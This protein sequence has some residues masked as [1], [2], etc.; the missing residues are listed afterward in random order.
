M[1]TF[2]GGETWSEND[3]RDNAPAIAT[4]VASTIGK[5]HHVTGILAS[6]STARVGEVVITSGAQTLGRVFVHNSGEFSFPQPLI[7]LSSTAVTATLA[8]SGAPGT[9]GAITLIGYTR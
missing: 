3:N 6:Y 8:A 1:L 2:P 7:G 4:R 5:R 9:F